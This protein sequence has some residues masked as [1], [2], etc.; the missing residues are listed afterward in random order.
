MSNL[1]ARVLTALVAIPILLH[2]FRRRTEK[3]VEFPAV[4]LL[5]KAP[6]QQQRRRRLRE[7][8][9]LAL[10]ITALTLLA[11]AF[12]RPY[13]SG[14]ASALPLPTTVIA[15]DTSLSL[16]APGQF[17]LAQQAARRALDNGSS[18]ERSGDIVAALAQFERSQKLDPSPTAD[19]AVNRLR[20]RMRTEGSAAFINGRQY[21]A[22][23]RIEQ[24]IGA[25]EVA[26]RYLT[27]DDPNKQAAR[28]RLA[29]L[30]VR[31]K[32]PL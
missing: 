20:T 12:A 19:A 28:D 10:R 15:L 5:H 27:D 30:R 23:D 2:L 6:V 17:A 4:R 16:S 32:S 21:D 7:L 11:V 29:V 26:V 13:V 9:L 22:L 18:L 1:A 14:R 3:V 31:Q 24:A 25:Y 8:I